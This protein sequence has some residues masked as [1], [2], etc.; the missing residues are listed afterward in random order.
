[1]LIE[2]DRASRA[3]AAVAGDLDR[4]VGDDPG[5]HKIL[6]MPAH[7]YLSAGVKQGSTGSVRN[8]AQSPLDLGWHGADQAHLWRPARK[9][10][11]L[12][13]YRPTGKVP[14]GELPSSQG[15]WMINAD[16]A[17]PPANGRGGDVGTS[18]GAGKGATSALPIPSSPTL[19][20]LASQ[21]VP[22]QHASYLRH[23]REAIENPRNLNIAL[24]GRYGTGKS[25]V[26][27]EFESEFESRS[28]RIAISTLGPKSEDLNL[29]NRIQKEL[30]KQLLYRAAPRALRYSRF[31]RIVPLSVK[32]AA[33]Q[34]AI[35]VIVVGSILGFLRWLPAV[36]KTGPGHPWPVRLSSWLALAILVTLLITALH[37]F[38][39]GRFVVSNVSA[40]GATVTLTQQNST[41][42]DE[43]LEEIV[44]FFD[45]LSPAVVI[46]ED[47]DRFDDPHIFEALRELNTLLNQTAKRRKK[48]KPLHFIYA[49][50]DSLFE[51]L[52]DESTTT[53]GD[54][55][56]AETVRANR[57]KFFDIVIPIVPFISHRNARELLAGLLQNRGYTGIERPLVSLVAQ[58]TTDMR[59]LRNICNEYAVFAERLILTSKTAPG[60]TASNLFALVVYKNYHLRDFEDISRRNSDLDTLYNGRRELVR[61]AIED[62]E[63]RK[64]ELLAEPAK[65]MSMEQTADQLGKR[66][67]SL[68]N[69]Y[70]SVHNLPNR[71]YL[72]F[73][74]RSTPYTQDEIASNQFWAT[75]VEASEVSIFASPHPNS[76]GQFMHKLNLDQIQ[77]YFPEALEAHQWTEIEDKDYASAL[78]KIDKD[79]AFLR[80]ADFKDLASASR[81]TL[82]VES[83]AKT[84]GA[85]IDATL[86]SQL[87]RDLVRQGYLDRNFA[88]YAAQ[89]YGEFTGVDVATFIVQSVQTNTMDI[90]YTFSGQ[91]AIANLLLEVPEDF[92]YTI[93][94]YNVH[95]LNY[96]L[97]R[98]DPLAGN[99]ADTIASHFESEAKEFLRA[100]FNS[101]SEPSRLAALLSKR[102]WDS[103][104]EYLVEDSG[105]P[106]NIQPALVDAALRASKNVE[107]Y[108]LPSSVRDYIIAA[109]LDMAVFTSHSDDEVIDRVIAFVKEVGAVLPSLEGLDPAIRRRVVHEELYHLTADNLREALEIAGGISIDEVRKNARVYAY[110]MQKLSIYLTL[111]ETDAHTCYSVLSE[112]ALSDFLKVAEA[113][114][115]DDVRKLI[116][117]AAPESQLGRLDGIPT[118]RWPVLAA[119]DLFSLTVVN[120][121]TYRDAIGSI[122]ESLAGLLVRAGSIDSAGAHQDDQMRTAVE[123]LNG[124][125]FI[126]DTRQRVEL[127]VS[128]NLEEY[129]PPAE[130]VPTAG[131]LLALLLTHNVI[132]DSYEAFERFRSAGWQT[133]ENAIAKS[134]RFV[135]FMTPDL[136]GDFIE[137]LLRSDAVPQEVR[138]VVI[139]N[140]AQYLPSDDAA[141]LTA[142]GSYAV[143]RGRRVPLDQ[144][145]RISAATR[146]AMLTLDLLV[147][148]SPMPAASD[149]IA[150]LTELGEPYSNLTSR[151]RAEFD[152]SATEDHRPLFDRLKEANHISEFKKR[153]GK[154]S[155]AVKLA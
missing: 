155:Y 133:I 121:L 89:F 123:V 115:A 72:Q 48:K 11:I 144:V 50:K 46:F 51:R 8:G 88:L 138:D 18:G 101:G 152:V 91:E 143:A 1:V 76:S 139:D 98:D 107:A 9:V 95:I 145:R 137:D 7:E 154:D 116:S 6:A 117:M 36:A 47:L 31:N 122:D 109:Y 75:L 83:G 22:E 118:S 77:M 148:V 93:S 45:E 62:C 153:R 30:V 141:A 103:I 26:L 34:A 73:S 40:A 70:K 74:V 52:G 129:V 27:D 96:L 105:I 94:A 112:A 43:Y 130:I 54:A 142:A 38:I 136:V 33:A 71:P 12:R 97:N 140:L 111:V 79:L 68:G 114:E 86:K 131:D 149:L 104:F 120:V 63:K 41:Y 15:L 61:S 125:S 102:P 44:Y 151:A 135:E 106:A 42:F 21:Y 35:A 39:Y 16:G 67:I 20:S 80:G 132:E 19:E 113:C 146:D 60:L 66:L 87:A 65:Y 59:L 147:A 108:N 64:R 69:L 4:D 127:V 49:I 119:H 57:T 55:A 37:R 25:S 128:L 81:F 126:P 92:S 100:Y 85:F 24:T 14:H 32:R 99:L 90:D 150:V 134:K 10:W 13:R 2:D 28:L 17:Q 23:L 5:Y 82:P 56:A 53:K 58:H 84:F 110:C 3:R 78:A 29:T 124:A